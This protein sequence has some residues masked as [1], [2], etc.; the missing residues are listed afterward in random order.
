MRLLQRTSRRAQHPS[1]GTAQTTFWV[2]GLG[3]TFHQALN[4]TQDY[5][6]SMPAAEHLQA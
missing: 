2:Q 5:I 6:R 3:F 4:I 1:L